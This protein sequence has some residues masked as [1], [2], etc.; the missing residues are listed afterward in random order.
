M[1][2]RR[3]IWT[4]QAKQLEFMSRSEYEALYGGAAGGGK[5]DALL[6]EALRQVDNPNY[7]GVILR[8]T[9]PMLVDL[10]ERSHELYKGAFKKASYNDSRH[11]W[12]FPS[13][14]RIE[15]GSM[16]HE[17]DRLKYQGRHFD[18]IAFDELTQFSWKEYSYLMSRNRPSG[19]GTIV[20]I[21]ASANPG[22]VGHAWVKDRFVT[23]ATPET[24]ITSTYRIIG[25]NGQIIERQR[26]RIFI[27][28]SVFD[29]KIL[30]A[31][32]PNYVANLAMMS[33]HEKQALLYGNWDSF[34]G[35]V[36]TEFRN[37][38]HG[39][40]TRQW[41]H[42]IKP[43]Q[44]PSDWL[45]YRGIDYGYT[46]P[47]SV[48]WYGV[49]HDGVIYRIKEWYGCTNTPNTGLKLHPVEIAKGIYEREHE[50]PML[51]GR[52]II[53]VADPAIFEESKGGSVESMLEQAPYFITNDK[54][55]HKRHPGLM[56]FHYRLAFDENGYAMFYCFDTCKEFIRTIP[57][58]VYDDKNVEDIDTEGEDHIYDECRYVMMERPVSPR[59]NALYKDPPEDPLNMFSS[60]AQDK[61]AFYRTW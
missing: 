8:K 60:S 54:G 20:Y 19:P 42:V 29:N 5:S 23:A 21:R 4:P 31:N 38:P 16:Q 46:R 51:K 15:F 32:D 58:L 13:G 36:F 40:E 41:S 2:K 48:G 6:C 24:P 34:D 35:Q 26:K 11:I 30:L 44:I 28:A 14:A 55:D 18:Y 37:D 33:E 43:F 47:F 27:P 39:Y 53:G 56:Q 17:A 52:R 61:Y 1:K 3:T 10:I 12:R 9:Y 49:D 7:S 22:G 25:P 57:A 45:I 59:K 50:D